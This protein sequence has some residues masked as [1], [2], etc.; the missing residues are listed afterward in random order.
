MSPASAVPFPEGGV[1]ASV[2]PV[3]TAL[4]GEALLLERLRTGDG[5][6]FEELVRTH[7]PRMLSVARSLLR[8]NEEDARDAVQDAFLSAFRSIGSFGGQCC[9]GTWLHR[10]TVN[11]ALMKIR[12]RKRRPERPLEDLL[13]RFREDGHYMEPPAAWP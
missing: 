5:K 9:V 6:A 7:T 3:D 2:S 12:T 13:P 4:A 1:R 11:A 8:R 10:I